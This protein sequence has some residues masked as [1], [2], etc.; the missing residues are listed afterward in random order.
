[1][2]DCYRRLCTALEML[3][4]MCQARTSPHLPPPMHPALPET[5]LSLMAI[6]ER[7]Q[8]RQKLSFAETGG[9]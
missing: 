2:Q 8:S 1:M 5:I 4:H 3:L 6:N 7:R 9:F